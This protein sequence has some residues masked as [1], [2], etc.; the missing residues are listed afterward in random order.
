MSQICS[1]V[2]GF[3]PSLNI[4]FIVGIIGFV[5]FTP[6]CWVYLRKAKNASLGINFAI[7]EICKYFLVVRNGRYLY[8]TQR[9]SVS[10]L[11]NISLHFSHFRS[12]SPSPRGL[13]FHPGQDYYFI[14][15]SSRTD[16]HRRVGGSCST[17]NMKVI[18][19]VAEVSEHKPGPAINTARE[20]TEVA[21][22]YRD[23]VRPIQDVRQFHT[24]LDHGTKD[25]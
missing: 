2:S 3:K 11:I 19:K 16:L 14:S 5:Y 13:E 4:E 6:S 17:H 1:C 9:I 23:Y 24:G 25:R 8:I 21:S 12:F 10:V 15:T 22:Q 18:F 7:T 20:R